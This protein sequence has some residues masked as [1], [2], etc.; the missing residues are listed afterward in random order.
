[1]ASK[2]AEDWEKF[3]AER[4][5]RAV[6]EIGKS[7]N[8]RYFMRQLLLECGDSTTPDGNNAIEAAKA[9]GRHQIGKSLVASLLANDITLYPELLKEDLLE[10]QLRENGGTYEDLE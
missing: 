7:P 8:L 4:E 2:T 5:F 9:I 1:M 6:E 10:H 3:D